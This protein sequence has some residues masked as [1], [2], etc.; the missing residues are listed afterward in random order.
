GAPSL[1]TL[2]V[3]VGG[4]S[5]GARSPS[6]GAVVPNVARYAT[7]DAAA[8]SSGPLGA[9]DGAPVDT[10]W[11]G[12]SADTTWRGSVWRGSGWRGSVGG[13]D[14]VG[15]L[16]SRRCTVGGSGARRDGCGAPPMR[17]AGSA[18]GSSEPAELSGPASSLAGIASSGPG[19]SGTAASWRGGSSMAPAE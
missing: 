4:D 16:L 17:G 18:V 3:R 8:T 5:V 7:S 19:G 15:V 10:V 14:A 6:S 1:V 9:P 12:A 13:G 11:G 2:P